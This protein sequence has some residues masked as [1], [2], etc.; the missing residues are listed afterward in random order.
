MNQICIHSLMPDAAAEYYAASRGTAGFD[1]DLACRQGAD[2]HLVA[3]QHGLCVGHCSLWWERVSSVPEARPGVIGHYMAQNGAVAHSMLTRACF[4]L[5][6]QGCTVA[7]GPMDG[8]IW[9][10]YRLIT[11]DSAGLIPLFPLEVSTPPDYP[12]HWKGAGFVPLS[13]G[14]HSSV[15]DLPVL[16]DLR[17]V[18]VAALL[19]RQGVRVR[20]MSMKRLE[21][22]LTRLQPVAAAAFAGEPFYT[23]PDET[24]FAECYLRARAHLAPELCLVAERDKQPVGYVL[25][26]L[27]QAVED[28]R[29]L[30]VI[31]TLAV[32]PERNLIGLGAWMADHIY[33]TAQQMG[34]VQVVHAMV[35]DGSVAA[36]IHAKAQVVFRRY[37]LFGRKLR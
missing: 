4:L 28:T 33:K 3:S 18:N 5:R 31:R 25:G 21:Q 11:F 37:R 35:R 34:A 26:A 14:F 19:K 6:E 32:L 30:A 8:N 24:D 36:N 12:D 15:M 17:L 16:S 1:V 29:T 2:R 23:L 20:L 7:V 10:D 27:A 22:E 9:R 13:P